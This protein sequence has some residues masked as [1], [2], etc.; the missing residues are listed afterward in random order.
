[1]QNYLHLELENK[2][3][4][5]ILPFTTSTTPTTSEY[6]H[7]VSLNAELMNE[8]VLNELIKILKTQNFF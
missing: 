5:A 7:S 3:V 4:K 1:M 6:M 2:L 8:L